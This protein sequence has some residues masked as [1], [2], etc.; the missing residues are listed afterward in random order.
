MILLDEHSYLKLWAKA[1]YLR[2]RALIEKMNSDELTTHL[3]RVLTQL[4]A[5]PEEIEHVRLAVQQLIRD[6]AP[7]ADSPVRAT[8]RMYR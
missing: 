1:I 3:V 2:D 4:Y 5:Q 8:N 7:P 6:D